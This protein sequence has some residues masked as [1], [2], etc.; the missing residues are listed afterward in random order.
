MSSFATRRLPLMSIRMIGCALGLL[1][2][3]LRDVDDRAGGLGARGA[4][5]RGCAAV[6][7]AACGGLAAVGVGPLRRRRR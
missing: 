1:G 5:G 4:V 3:A 2:L 6:A 7:S